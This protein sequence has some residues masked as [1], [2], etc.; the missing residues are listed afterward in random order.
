M[1]L[2]A[3]KMR[4]P[5]YASQRRDQ[6]CS[7]STQ[8]NTPKRS[9][10]P[11]ASD[12]RVRGGRE[13]GGNE[14]LA[15]PN[16]KVQFYS[17]ICTHHTYIHTPYIHTLIHHTYIHTCVHIHMLTDGQGARGFGRSCTGCRILPFP[18]GTHYVQN[19]PVS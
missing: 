9:H 11:A 12:R 14:A 2:Y 10:P 15:Q 16:S 3:Q 1:T 4:G 5:L 8:L 17:Y 13:R 19:P 7:H 18:V 6:V